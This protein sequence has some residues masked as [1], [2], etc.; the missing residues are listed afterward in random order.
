MLHNKLVKQVPHYI[1][2][3]LLFSGIWL[4]FNLQQYPGTAP[5]LTAK[6]ISLVLYVVLGA[7]ALRGKTRKIRYSA[8]VAALLV[9]SYM[10]SVALTRSVR[11]WWG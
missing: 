8:L 1:D 6:L 9:F 10:V 7:F 5:W 4:A 3:I 11:P 2:T